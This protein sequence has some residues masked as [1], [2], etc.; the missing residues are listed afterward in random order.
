MSKDPYA[1]PMQAS[2]TAPP[3]P[4]GF[5][6]EKQTK[7][8]RGFVNEVATIDKSIA[9]DALARTNPE[10]LLRAIIKA[11]QQVTKIIGA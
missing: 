6:D 9:G 5:L 1:N 11:A 4:A 3:T 10:E 2:I 8:A 7:V